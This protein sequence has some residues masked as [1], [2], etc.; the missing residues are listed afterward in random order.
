MAETWHVTLTV[1]RTVHFS[2]TAL[3]NFFPAVEDLGP[4]PLN[5]ILFNFIG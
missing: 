3:I 5:K 2:E 4:F 1:Q